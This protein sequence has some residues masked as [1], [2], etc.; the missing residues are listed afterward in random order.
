LT[1]LHIALSIE[2]VGHQNYFA[3]VTVFTCISTRK[4]YK[5][6]PVV[7]LFQNQQPT[8]FSIQ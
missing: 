1:S 5:S 4:T 2:D 7:S 6:K 3:A 8:K